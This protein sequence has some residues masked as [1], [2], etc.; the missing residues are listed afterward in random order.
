[1][2]SDGY[3]TM[4]HE[5]VSIILMN[6][7]AYVKHVMFVGLTF[8][9]FF[10]GVGSGSC[11]DTSR[12]DVQLSSWDWFRCCRTWRDAVWSLHGTAYLEVSF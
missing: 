6:D 1:M 3:D 4:R 7:F 8:C 10:V 9:V 5:F 12:G 2:G 11:S